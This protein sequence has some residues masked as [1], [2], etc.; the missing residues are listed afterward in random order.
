[1]D[2]A[3]CVAGTDSGKAL[4]AACRDLKVPNAAA[5]HAHDEMSPVIR[6]KKSAMT[7]GQLATFKR[8]LCH[9]KASCN[10]TLQ[11]HA[12]GWR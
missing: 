12:G 1:M 8:S 4:L 9:E 11:R 6:L 10:R 2:L 3:T 5:R 7:E